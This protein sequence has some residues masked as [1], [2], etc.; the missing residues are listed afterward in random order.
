M[1]T[2]ADY[3]T[4]IRLRLDDTATSG[5]RW[6]DAE[7]NAYIGDAARDYSKYFS[8]RREQEFSTNGTDQRYDV[9]TDLIDDQIIDVLIRD[10]TSNCE[11]AIPKRQLALRG[12][13]R[14]WEVVG[15][16]LVFGYIPSSGLTVVTRYNALHDIPGSGAGT[17]PSEDDDII[18]TYVMATAWQRIG[19]NDAGLSRWTEDQKRDDSPII[20][21][22]VR[23]WQRYM[24]L[25]EQ[26][27]NAVTFSRR[28]RTHGTWR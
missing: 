26:K 7:L 15:L 19:G 27:Q 14:Y 16:E 17:I 9:P 12:S 21:H 10:T 23:L 18:Y 13:T 3:L 4:A 2:K 24:R 28:V 11:Y 5:Q 8:R 1:T 22:Y 25:I 20:P 6:S